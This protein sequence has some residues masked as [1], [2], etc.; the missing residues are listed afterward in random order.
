MDNIWDK[1][2]FDSSYV[3]GDDYTV[4]TD[5]IMDLEEFLEAFSDTDHLMNL[6]KFLGAYSDVKLNERGCLHV[7]L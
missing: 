1:D 7:E 4:R 6:E 5:H 3:W 2:L